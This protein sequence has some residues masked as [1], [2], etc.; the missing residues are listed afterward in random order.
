MSAFTYAEEE[1][2]PPYYSNI[3]V[4]I[5][6][7]RDNAR[8]YI[9]F[10]NKCTVALEDMSDFADIWCDDRTI[11]ACISHIFSRIPAELPSSALVPTSKFLS[12]MYD[13]N[14]SSSR[15]REDWATAALDA[16]V[17]YAR[18]LAD[19]SLNEGCMYKVPSRKRR[20]GNCL[21]SGK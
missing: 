7:R 5:V 12:M 6:S 9:K 8:E 14:I 20:F 15:Q 10:I 13:G 18:F 3:W 11:S 2:D 19:D 17:R 1:E 21:T 4:S 16:A